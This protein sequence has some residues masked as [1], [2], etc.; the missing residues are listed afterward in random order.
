MISQ[1]KF[2]HKLLCITNKYRNTFIY[3]KIQQIHPPVI[4]LIKFHLTQLYFSI[5]LFL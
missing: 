3:K 4:D 5:I 2:V 1:A